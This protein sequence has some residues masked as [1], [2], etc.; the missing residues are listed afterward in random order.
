MVQYYHNLSLSADSTASTASVS[1]LTVLLVQ[2]QS[3]YWQYY[4]C[5]EIWQPALPCCMLVNGTAYMPST[6]FLPVVLESLTA[7]WTMANSGTFREK[8]ISWFHLGLKPESKLQPQLNATN[9]LHNSV[10]YLLTHEQ[11]PP[12]LLNR[13]A[14]ISQLMMV[15][16]YLPSLWNLNT[17]LAFKV[18]SEWSIIN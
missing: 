16:K 5:C 3:Q 6:A 11:L 9:I 10:I 8:F 4:Y 18:H 1:V 17:H 15:T 14:W 13:D 7:K 2:P 12:S